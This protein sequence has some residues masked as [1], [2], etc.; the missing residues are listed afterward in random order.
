MIIYL[1][2]FVLIGFAVFRAPL[3]AVLL[4]V[5]MLG[6]FLQEI[7]LSAVAIEIYRLADMPL[8]MALPFFAFAGYLMAHS[9]TSQRL[10]NL[11]QV[12]LGWMPGGLAIVALVCITYWPVLS[13][14]LTGSLS[15]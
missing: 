1:L 11:A 7:P 5:A 14:A 2:I 6:F 13:L 4:S 9:N 12:F 15:K 10:V 8:L 3:F